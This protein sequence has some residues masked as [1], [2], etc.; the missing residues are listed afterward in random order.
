MSE[1]SSFL[2]CLSLPLCSLPSLCVSF[3]VLVFLSGALM[4]SWLI[5]PRWATEPQTFFRPIVLEKP[6]GGEG[7]LLEGRSVEIGLGEERETG[8]R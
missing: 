1:L 3:V 2:F 7:T 5:R 6:L 8:E 4:V